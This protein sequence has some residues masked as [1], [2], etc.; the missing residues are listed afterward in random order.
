MFIKRRIFYDSDE[1]E[2]RL[3][4]YTSFSTFWNRLGGPYAQGFYSWTW[5]GVDVKSSVL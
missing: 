2:I 5:V 1:T 3:S 4:F